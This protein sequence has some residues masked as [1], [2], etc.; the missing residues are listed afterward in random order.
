MT[1]TDPILLLTGPPG[2]GKTTVARHLGALFPRSVHLESDRFFRFIAGG[3]VEP[4]RREA[5]DQNT[6]VME[7][8]EPDAAL[9]YATAGYF[10]IVDGILSPTG[11]SSRCATRCWRGVCGWL[12]WFCGRRSVSVSLVAGIGSSRAFRTCPGD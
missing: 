9:G 3:F 4:W 5:H 10:T 12:L 6:V 7:I 1:T 8:V 11:S 2:A